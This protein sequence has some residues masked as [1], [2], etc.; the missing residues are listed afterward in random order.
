MRNSRAT[1]LLIFWLTTVAATASAEA[2]FIDPA[3]DP[4]HLGSADNILF[5]TP[6]QQVAG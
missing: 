3:D 4:G 1:L 6:E 2:P 5:W